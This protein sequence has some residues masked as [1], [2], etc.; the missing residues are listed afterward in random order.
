MRD[1]DVHRLL[2][3][4][5]KTRPIFHSEADFQHALAWTLHQHHP[6]LQ[7]R[8]EYPPSQKNRIHVDVW[9]RRGNESLA[10]ELKY[11]CRQLLAKINGEQFNL[12]GHA[13]QD[14][15]RYDTIKDICRLEELRRE[16]PTLTAYVILLTNDSAYWVTPGSRQTVSAAFRLHEG[17]IL[18]GSLEWG[19][20][21]GPGTTKGRTEVL[22]LRGSYAV[23]WQDYSTVSDGAYSRFK[24][25]VVRIA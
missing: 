14:L 4:V 18:Q 12:F 17:Q 20:A 22:G 19:A 11:K 24:Y 9:A 7:I 16:D 15:G 13:A 25:C 5:A 6:G 3:E 1:I 21:A 8:L 2:G 23:R 10:F